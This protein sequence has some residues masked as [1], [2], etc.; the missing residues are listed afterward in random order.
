MLTNG[1]K[2]M[3]ML[4]HQGLCCPAQHP[5]LVEKR[6]RV[7]AERIVRY[8]RAQQGGQPPGEQD[9]DNARQQQQQQNGTD[10]GGVRRRPPVARVT[11]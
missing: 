3:R 5:D 9:G 1:P 6:R 4:T 8:L 11:V 2:H 7:F 10:E